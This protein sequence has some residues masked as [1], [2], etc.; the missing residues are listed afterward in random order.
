MLVR[1]AF[2]GHP[3]QQ[4]LAQLL[5]ARV[6]ASALEEVQP[7]RLDAIE[8]RFAERR[9]EE[10][11]LEQRVERVEVVA[12]DAAG[13]VGHLLVHRR[14]VSRGHRIQLLEDRLERV[15]LGRAAGHQA[16][17]QRRQPFLALSDPPPIRS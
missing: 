3:E 12:V 17:R 8:V 11:V 13:E 7:L 9:R 1:R 10:R 6:A 14:A 16:R 2:V 5:V 4:L 15:L